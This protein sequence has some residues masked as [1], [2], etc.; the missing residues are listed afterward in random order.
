MFFLYI[1]RKVPKTRIFWIG[2]NDIAK[3]GQYVWSGQPRTFKGYVDRCVWTHVINKLRGTS[4]AIALLYR[5]MCVFD[6]GPKPPAPHEDKLP[7]I[8]ENRK[9][10][11]LN[12]RT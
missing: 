5:R 9:P 12:A 7:Y 8:C 4:T 1:F 11:E 2:L 3:N 6:E 10:L